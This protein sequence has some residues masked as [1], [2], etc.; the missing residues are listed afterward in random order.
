MRG[1]SCTKWREP[2]LTRLQ[3]AG[4]VAAQVTACIVAGLMFGLVVAYA[5][6]G[7]W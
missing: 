2:R 5:A 7:S 4:L 1:L 6:G 3:R